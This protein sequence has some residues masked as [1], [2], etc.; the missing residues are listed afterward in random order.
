MRPGLLAVESLRH[1]HDTSRFNCGKPP[2]DRWL[3]RH[4]LANQRLESSRTFVVCPEDDHQRVV[5]YYSLTVASILHDR[6]PESVAAG[7]PPYPIPV[8][9]LA[10]LAV[11]EEFRPPHRTLGI[12]SGLLADSLVRT[13]RV[14]DEV[15]IRAMLVDALDDEAAAWYRRFGFDPSPT[16]DLQLFLPMTRIRESVR[17]AA[18]S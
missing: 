8:M 4:A 5:A 18:Q 6:A 2:L 12:G 1:D 16:G 13:V 7:M 15:G 10:R 9:L 17:A 3:V 14:A 11:D